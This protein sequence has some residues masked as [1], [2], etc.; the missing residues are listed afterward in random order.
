[1]AYPGG[2]AEYLREKTEKLGA[3]RGEKESELFKGHNFY[4]NGYVGAMTMV[5]MKAVAASHG[6]RVSHMLNQAVTLVIATQMTF[7]KRNSLTQPVVTPEWI[8]ASLKAAAVLDWKPFR[9]FTNVS[10]GQPLLNFNLLDCNSDGFIENYFKSS[11][12]HHLSTWKSEL[13]NYCAEQT[14]LR[15]IAKYAP[16]SYR[17][18]AII[19][20]I[21]LDCFF[22]SVATRSRPDLVDKP[23]VIAHSV[24]SSSTKSTSEIACANYAARKFGIANGTYLGAALEKCP[25]LAVLKYDFEAYDSVSKLFYN[26]LLE[27]C[28]FIQAVSCDEAFIDVTD[29][30]DCRVTDGAKPSAETWSMQKADEIR[31]KIHQTIQCHASIGIGSCPLL[32]RVATKKAKPNG[33]FFLADAE[34]KDF[35]SDLRVGDLPG[36]GYRTEEKL[37]EMNIKTC[38]QIV[39]EGHIS[40]R[41]IFGDIQGL[42][43]YE[44]SMGV[45]RRVLENKCRA[46]ISAEI[47]WGIRFKTV[48]QVEI[49]IDRLSLNLFR[50]M[51]TLKLNGKLLTLKIKQKLYEGEPSK[52]L[53]CG[54]C[55]D[56]SKSFQV[57]S[58]NCVSSIMQPTWE[59]F[60]GL[61]IAPVDIRGIGIHIKVDAPMEPS[62]Q[63]ID[64]MFLQQYETTHTLSPLDKKRKASP[65]KVAPKRHKSNPTATDRK[66]FEWKYGIKPEDV[67]PTILLGLPLD[68]RDEL[69]DMGL[70][71]VSTNGIIS[72]ITNA[73]SN[74]SPK[75]EDQDSRIIPNIQGYTDY[76]TICGFLMEWSSPCNMKNAPEMEDVEIVDV[77][78]LDLAYD[79]SLDLAVQVLQILKHRIVGSKKG[80]HHRDWPLV[81]RKLVESLNECVKLLHGSSI[82]NLFK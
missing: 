79:S 43:M 23:V 38:G 46:S 34:A 71:S 74:A 21:D 42:K 64:D 57:Q 15:N 72:E 37:A 13:A 59:L 50:R 65:S 25:S 5:E 36:L 19:M 68:I 61:H 60:K 4:F 47:N 58:I 16:R 1:M 24:N 73:T 6:A 3:Q 77:Y 56:H 27:N 45:D 28:D 31:K 66:L 52:F 81:F 30:F 70:G 54:H 32:A 22:A 80:K 7:S 14:K 40:L 62:Q 20:H 2:F 55:K 48:Q 69:L 82:L 18:G 53:G 44:F 10:E 12:L 51:E 67:D 9:L 8:H 17:S 11:R 26:I 39:R 33:V 41:D 35:M 78:L 29:Q 63:T 49:F 75:P 76:E